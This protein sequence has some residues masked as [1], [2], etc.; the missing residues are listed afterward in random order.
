MLTRCL[1]G[2]F[3]LSKA[4]RFAL[5]HPKIWPFMVMPLVISVGFLCA[6]WQLWNVYDS[7]LLAY[8]GGGGEG[9]WS[10]IL[11]VFSWLVYAVFAWYT[12]SMVGMVLASPFNDLLATHVLKARGI[13]YSDPPLW[14]SIKNSVVDS[15]K[16]LVF[17]VILSVLSLCFPPIFFASIALIVVMDHFD[18]PWSHQTVGLRGRLKC[19]RRDAPEA[20]GFGVFYGL[21]FMIPFAGLFTMPLAVIS[22]ALLVRTDLADPKA[23]VESTN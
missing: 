19:F 15:L 23:P 10:W 22:A 11:D 18:Y 5:V 20:L 16:L 13:A 21:V 7:H 9:W 2:F 12:F 17:K 1:A 14:T 6:S 3:S 4:L 8:L